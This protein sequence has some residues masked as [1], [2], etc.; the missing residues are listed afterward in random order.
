MYYDS[1]DIIIINY[2]EAKKPNKNNINRAELLEILA[3]IYSI[4]KEEPKMN[5]VINELI[6]DYKNTDHE[7]NGLMTKFFWNYNKGDY[8]EAAKALSLISEKYRDD[9][10]IQIA[11]ALIGSENRITF[12]K[13]IENENSNLIPDKYNL[14]GNY[15]NPFNPSTII[16]YSVPVNSN[17][18]ITIYDIMGRLV[19]SF[20]FNSQSSGYQNIE[21][22]GT[23]ETG[24]K[25]SSGTYV[26]RMEA[27][28]LE[29]NA[30]S[31]IQSRK[32]VL[33]K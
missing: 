4:S 3:G 27:V 22:N 23:N 8:Q 31:F 17:V 29:G 7:K 18:K 10:E 26:Y 6:M 20:S 21:W 2:L 14:I 11:L 24:V 16:N 12:K 30:E 25:V 33:L 9:K 19:K 32:M 1:K 15:P 5:E 13:E 28:S